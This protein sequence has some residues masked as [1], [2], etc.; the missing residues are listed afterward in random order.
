M[1]PGRKSSLDVHLLGP[2]WFLLSILLTTAAL[3]LPALSLDPLLCYFCPLQ[4]KSKPCP[5]VTSQCPPTE[6]CSSSRGRYGPVH[7]LSAQGCVKAELCGSSETVSYQGV[8]F[9]V[10]H[11]CCCKDKCNAPPKRE[12]QLKMLMGRIRDKIISSN[13]TDR[14]KKVDLSAILLGLTVFWWFID[15]RSTINDDVKVAAGPTMQQLLHAAV[16]W[17]YLLL[18]SL[19]CDN[20]RCYYSPIL[21][22]D[23]KF[24]L[25]ETECPP[26]EL[27][28]KADGRYGNHSAL[29]ARG[30][31]AKKDCAQVHRLRL[32]GTDYTMTYD[33]CDQ[34]YC[35]S[36]PGVAARCCSIIVS[37]LTA[38]VMARSL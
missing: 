15:E 25:I 23:D 35:N 33:C 12:S 13:I 21:D 31:M 27:C 2:H 17:L 11:T 5:N 26:D 14:E 18:P 28:F 16:L 29:S 22:K 32:K 4:L 8:E 34:P 38:A 6:R 1:G 7:I 24:E 9:N 19:L 10:S 20:L 37:L 30:C 3:I 36:C